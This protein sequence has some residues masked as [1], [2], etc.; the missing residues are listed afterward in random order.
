M[1][2]SQGHLGPKLHSALLLHKWVILPVGKGVDA[3]CTKAWDARRFT[4]TYV[5]PLH[6]HFKDHIALSN[7]DRTAY[8]STKP[9]VDV[10]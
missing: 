7:A 1:S 10:L 8:S 2:P 5:A 4:G 9:N 3:C 6:G